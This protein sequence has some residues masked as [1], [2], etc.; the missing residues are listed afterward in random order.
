MERVTKTVT[1]AGSG[2]EQTSVEETYGEAAAYP[3]AAGQTKF[4]RDIAGVETF[5]D[6]EAAAEHGAAHK[7]TAV[8]KV[9]GE[10]AAGQSR[11]TESFLAANDT[12]LVEQESVWD[13][14]NWLL[15]SSG[16]HEYDEEGRRTKTTRGNGRVT[17]TSWMCCG[18]LSETDEDGILT[19]Y[20]YN[21][22]HQLVETIRSEISDGDTVVTRKPSPPTPGRRRARP[23][24]A[25]GQG[26]HD[27][28]GKRGIRQARPYR[29]ANRCAGPRDGDSLQ[30]KRPDGNRHDARRRHPRHRTSPRRLR[31]P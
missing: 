18:K 27:H 2:Q 30:R 23:A 29:Q 19:S 31:T 16:A 4:T 17:S 1:A 11:K 28:D 6:Y 20:G 24:D 5:Y 25:P 9:G 8:T 3:Y 15:L 26:S 22:A 7:K 21:S 12:V 14:D 13:G 10:L